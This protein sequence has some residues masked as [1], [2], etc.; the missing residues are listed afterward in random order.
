MRCGG[1]SSDISLSRHSLHTMPVS[2]VSTLVST[3]PPLHMPV[4]LIYNGEF[5]MND[6]TCQQFEVRPA[7]L[8]ELSTSFERPLSM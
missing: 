2:A 5:E 7:I 6:I 1:S 3:V 8:P 4:E